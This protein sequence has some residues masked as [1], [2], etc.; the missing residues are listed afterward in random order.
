MIDGE[1]KDLADRYADGDLT[2]D[3]LAEFARTGLL[4]ARHG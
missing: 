1:M 2:A 3:D 4:P